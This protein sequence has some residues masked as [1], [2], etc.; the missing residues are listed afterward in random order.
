MALVNCPECGNRVS[1][2]AES[3]PECAYPLTG[4]AATQ[5]HE[6]QNHTIEHVAKRRKQW[7]VLLAVAALIATPFAPAFPLWSGIV[8]LVLCVTAFIPVI[9]GFSH[10]L[11]GLSAS[12]ARR[13]GL[14]VIM[15]GLIGL[16]L[17]YASRTGAEYREK[18]ERTSAQKIAATVEKVVE[19]AERR[20]STSKAN[21]K[22]KALV[23]EAETAWRNGNSLWAKNKLGW[24]SK[25][26]GASN[27]NLVH[28]LHVRMA[29]AQVV[30]LVK[31]AEEAWRDGNKAWME[32]KLRSASKVAKASDFDPVRRLRIR[33]ANAKVEALVVDAVNAIEA[34]DID[35]AKGKLQ[36]ALVVPHADALADA[37]KLDQ[38]IDNATD[39]SFI[40]TTLMEISDA[41][42]RKLQKRGDMPKQLVSTYKVLDSRAVALAKAQLADIATAREQRRQQRLKRERAAAEAAQKAEEERTT[43]ELVAAEAKRE[44]ERRERIEKGFSS[45]DGSHRGLTKHIKEIMN[46]PDSY[47]HVETE[48]WDKGDHLIVKATFRGKNAFGGVVKN[49]VMARVDL[50]GNVIAVISQS[51]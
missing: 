50:D 42:F 7:P 45:W 9:Q 26:P 46:D 34:S 3:C 21:A 30:S 43:R 5:A 6:G 27:L 8:L 38:Q 12:E 48:Y 13:S 32:K 36:A 15:Y 4:G 28:Q 29:N 47:D 2:R 51:P 11:L 40:R 10:R 25:V 35:A 37:N 14:R 16:V 18:K 23:A 31:E 17:I 49:W 24:A 22:V 19:Q 41:A 39:P 1:D 44:K 33:M 20:R